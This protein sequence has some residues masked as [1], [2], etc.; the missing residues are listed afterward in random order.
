MEDLAF[1][2]VGI[3]HA[4]FGGAAMGLFLGVNPYPVALLYSLVVAL[5]I[6]EFGFSLNLRENTM[7]GVFFSISMA[8]GYIFVTLGRSYTDAW[9]YL[10]GSVFTM[11]TGDLYFVG[12][13]LV[14]V[15]AW[16]LAF[17][18]KYILMA[19]NEELAAS[20]GVRVK[21]LRVV[22]LLLVTFSIVASIK[23]VGIILVNTLLVVPGAVGKIVG[24]S[25]RS[26]FAISVV[27]GVFLTLFGFCV[28]LKLD[29]PPGA[30]ISLVMASFLVLCLVFS[31]V[32]GRFTYHGSDSLH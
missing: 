30:V 4:A 2:G 1:S 7:I 27:V 18:D 14:M 5:L 10:F 12:L 26:F 11:D 8:L 6:V 23:L 25:F 16:L 9:S 22:L 31:K 15:V 19:Y 29:L 21:L 17:K 28:S 32:S 13:V 24:R 20:Y 3:S